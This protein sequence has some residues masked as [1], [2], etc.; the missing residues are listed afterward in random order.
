MIDKRLVEELNER[1][2]HAL[3]DS[4]AADLNKNLRALFTGWLDRFDLVTREDFDVQ[5]KL[6][7][8]V[9][10]KLAELEARIAELEIGKPGDPRR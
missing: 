5:K 4:P 2:A 6:L 8:R 9:Q 7:E 1:I 3:R 10:A